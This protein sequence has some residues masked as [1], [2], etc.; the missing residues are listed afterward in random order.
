MNLVI[1]ITLLLKILCVCFL[2]VVSSHATSGGV[3]DELS[4]INPVSCYFYQLVH[5]ELFNYCCPSDLIHV[6]SSSLSSV[7]THSNN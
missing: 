1:N 3:Y 5:Y 4:Q 6:W 2:Y 7:F